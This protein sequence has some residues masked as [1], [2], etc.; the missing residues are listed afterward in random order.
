MN[1]INALMKET[2]E[3]PLA[4]SHHYQVIAERYS[5][6]SRLSSD[7]ESAGTLILKFPASKTKKYIS[8]VCKPSSPDI[9]LQQPRLRQDSTAKIFKYSM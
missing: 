9:L 2:T 8:V 7:T 6:G 1:G 3:R 5:L 4:P